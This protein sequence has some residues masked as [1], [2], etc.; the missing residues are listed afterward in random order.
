MNF[1][2]LIKTAGMA[3]VLIAVWECARDRIAAPIINRADSTNGSVT[4]AYAKSAQTH[5]HDKVDDSKDKD[6]K[7]APKEDKS[8]IEKTEEATAGKKEESK[9][10]DADD[11]NPIAISFEKGFEDIAKGA[12]NSVVNVATM[13]IIEEHGRSAFPDMFGGDSPFDD[14]FREFFDFPRRRPPP[15]KAHALGSGFVIFVNKKKAYIVTNSHVVR[16]AN[17]VRVILSDKKELDAEMYAADHRTDIAILEVNLEGLDPSSVKMTAINWGDSE[18]LNE[19]NYVVAIGNPFG[20]GSTVTH[21]IVSAKGRNVALGGDSST[22]VEEFIQHSAP[23]NMGNSG[24]CLLNTKGEVVGINTAIYSPNGGSVGLGFA[25]PS[26]MARPIVEQLIARK[27]ITRGWLGVEV[28]PVNT[29]QAESV[30]L[31]K[32]GGLDP[33]RIFGAFV[34]KV[35]PQSPAEKAGV[36]E[37]DIVIQVNGMQVSERAPL[38]ALV[39]N[40]EVGKQIDMLV[41]RNQGGK[42]EANHIAVKIGNFEEAIDNGVVEQPGGNQRSERAK[43]EE[44]HIPELRCW[45]IPMPK[46]RAKDCPA[47]ARVIITRIKEDSASFGEPPLLPGDSIMNLGGV[48]ITTPQQL[49]QVASKLKKDKGNSDEPVSVVLYRDKSTRM[50]A[51]NLASGVGN[52]DK[53]GDDD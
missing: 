48:K 40:A 52:D 5:D 24:G 33:S 50:V 39:G 19:G 18:E 38:H 27:K 29:R 34:S 53:S 36:M 15:R 20:L 11:K 30:G 23:I 26:K 49:K 14:L 46:S 22:L 13:Q 16:N 7:G 21:G 43:N 1:L 25:I 8:K 9:T 17:K 35:V 41:W 45:V 32:K 3:I 2:K 31:I 47:G 51:V 12:M 4:D 6:H 28:H 37:G 10:G 44:A 42:W